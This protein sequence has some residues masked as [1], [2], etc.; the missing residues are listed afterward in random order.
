VVAVKY[1]IFNYYVLPVIEV[2]PIVVF[3]RFI[4]NELGN[5]AV[6]EEEPQKV[7]QI[8]LNNAQGLLKKG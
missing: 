1:Q 7:Q 2:N 4:I 8:M 5:N 6:K 3:V